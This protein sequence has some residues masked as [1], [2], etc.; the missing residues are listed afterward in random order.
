MCDAP[1]LNL[2][3]TYKGMVMASRAINPI[4]CFSLRAFYRPD[5]HVRSAML[6]YRSQHRS[7]VAAPMPN[8]G[9]IM[10]RRNDRA[11]PDITPSYYI[12][13]K[14]APIFIIIVTASALGIFNYQKSSSP[15]VAATLYA[16]R[17]SE[18]ARKE[19]G[20]EIYF[21]DLWPWIW[22]EMNQLHGRVNISFGVK[23]T[24]GR[25]VVRFKS[26][27]KSRMGYVSLASVHESQCWRHG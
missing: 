4:Q 3:Q 12:W 1:R 27:R 8:S 22:G 19:L 16:L 23:G 9:P 20:D 11:L 18:V 21:R 2:P 25:G 14:T 13:L 26:V 24:K 6:R 15:I 17:T 10:T 7:L 5:T